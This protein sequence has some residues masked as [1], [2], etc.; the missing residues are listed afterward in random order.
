MKP[1]F[2]ATDEQLK[3]EPWLEVYT[4]LSLVEPSGALDSK[5]PR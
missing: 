3:E 4:N 2:L 1:S 5:K